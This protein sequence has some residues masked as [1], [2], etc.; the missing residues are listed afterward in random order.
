MQPRWRSDGRE[1]FFLDLQGRV[2]SASLTPG[3]STEFS[4]PTTLFQ[5]PTSRAS[6]ALDQWG[7]T[8]DGQRFLFSES[9]P[10]DDW[11]SVSVVLNW[12]RLLKQ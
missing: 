12:P 7:V 11:T 9:I 6:P 8:R 3:S 4:A 5:S 10:H 2:M 1:L